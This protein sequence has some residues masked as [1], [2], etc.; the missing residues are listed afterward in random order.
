MKIL[1]TSVSGPQ[2]AA[3][4]ITGEPVAG[5]MYFLEDAT[6]KS[7]RQNKTYH[8]LAR[9]LWDSNCYSWPAISLDNLKQFILKDL[10]MGPLWYVYGGDDLKLHKVKTKQEIPEHIREDRERVFVREK[11][12]STY[13]LPEG[14]MLIKSLMV[15]MD[16]VGVHNKQFTE[17]QNEFNN[18]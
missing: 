11:G 3:R 14:H 5:K 2:I 8:L 12:W 10:G 6:S 1:I 13:T 18:N 9:I 7:R 16:N 15:Y 4:A 17:M